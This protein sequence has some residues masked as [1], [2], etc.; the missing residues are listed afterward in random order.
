MTEPKPSYVELGYQVVREATE[1]LPFQEIM[2][3]VNEIYP[4]QTRNPQ[5]TIRNAIHQSHL[6]VNTG[7]RR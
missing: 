6:V 1:P 2:E 7:N 4:I 5:A 3:R